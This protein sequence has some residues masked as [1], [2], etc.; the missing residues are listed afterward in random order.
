MLQ[1][2]NHHKLTQNFG[3]NAVISHQAEA[4]VQLL[5]GWRADAGKQLPELMIDLAQVMADHGFWGQV[6]CLLLGTACRN[7]VF[8]LRRGILKFD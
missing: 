8:L 2:Q 1:M 6:T 7:E 4:V 3:E 5:R